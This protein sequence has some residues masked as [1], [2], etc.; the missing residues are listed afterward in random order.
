MLH[1]VSLGLMAAA[2]VL[3]GNARQQGWKQDGQALAD[4]VLALEQI[5]NEILFRQAPLPEVL[6]L[7]AEGKQETV[8]GYLRALAAAL[9]DM[10]QEKLLPPQ[11]L[12]V[13]TPLQTLFGG[14]DAAGEA[15]LLQSLLTE[16]QQEHA[17]L[18]E[19]ISRRCRT[20]QALSLAL[21]AVCVIVLY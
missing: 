2:I 14:Y 13:L 10:P 3:S 12:R 16:A 15:R 9:R 17:R 7:A 21:A 11:P 19:E 1:V 5:R 4:Y 8:A 20:T 18:Q 6:L